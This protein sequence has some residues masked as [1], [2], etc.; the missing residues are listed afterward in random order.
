MARVAFHEGCELI[1]DPAVCRRFPC[2]RV[3]H[4]TSP[5]PRTAAKVRARRRVWL[6]AEVFAQ[7]TGKATK[8]QIRDKRFRLPCFTRCVSSQNGK[9]QKCALRYR[10]GATSAACSAKIF[11][12]RRVLRLPIASVNTSSGADSIK[13][14]EYKGTS[15]QASGVPA[16]GIRATQNST[17]ARP[18]SVRRQTGGSL[19][20]ITTGR[21]DD[22]PRLRR[23]VAD[24]SR[25]V[26]AC[27]ISVNSPA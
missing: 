17:S 24:V 16:A 9:G 1:H 7:Y 26:P 11:C 2:A 27:N 13:Y 19:N 14:C 20:N 15:R 5:K 23:G 6:H 21:R 18:L 12:V 10:H 22:D 8:E 4:R 25:H 3:A